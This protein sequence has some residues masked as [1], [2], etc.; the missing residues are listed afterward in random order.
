MFSFGLWGVWYRIVEYNLIFG[1]LSGF[2]IY[3]LSY[4]LGIV[5]CFRDR[6]KISIVFDFKKIRKMM[7]VMVEDCLG[8]YRNIEEGFRGL[9]L[10]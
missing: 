4:I 1:V 2:N 8:R 3:L 6:D 9:E 7:S 10:D 5:L